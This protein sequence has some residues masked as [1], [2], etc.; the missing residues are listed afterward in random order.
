MHFILSVFKELSR[1]KTRKVQARELQPLAAKDVKRNGNSIRE[2][3]IY[4]LVS[5]L[6]TSGFGLYNS[7]TLP[8]SCKMDTNY[9]LSRLRNA[10]APYN[11]G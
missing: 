5:K 1:S 3:K 7:K 4:L 2:V 11:R 8:N 6:C 10:D 9:L